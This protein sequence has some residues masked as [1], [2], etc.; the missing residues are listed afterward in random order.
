VE[1]LATLGG[2]A[3]HELRQLRATLLHREAIVAQMTDRPRAAE[4]LCDKLLR[5]HGDVPSYL[6]GR[7]FTQLINARR[8]QFKL[9]EIDRLDALARQHNIDAKS[10]LVTVVHDCVIGVA[11]QMAGRT[12]AAVSSLR[13]ALRAAAQVDGRGGAYGAIAALPLAEIHF[14]RNEIESARKLV[15]DFLP[16]A[17]DGGLGDQ[18][19]SGWLTRARLA[20]LESGEAPALAVLEEAAIIASQRG[21]RRMRLIVGAE[22]IKLLIRVG[23]TTDA[24]H[25]AHEIQV[26]RDSAR[27]L[28]SRRATLQEEAEALAWVRL[29]QAHNRITEALHVAKQWRSHLATHG[30]RGHL[31]CWEILLVQLFLLQGQECAATRA[32]RSALT[33]AAPGRLIRPF[34]DEGPAVASLIL[35]HAQCQSGSTDAAE[36]FAALIASELQ[37]GVASVAE[38][39]AGIVSAHLAAALSQTEI[40]VLAMAGSGMRNCDVGAR[41]GMTEGSVKWCLQQI[42]DKIGVRKRSQAVDRA[43]RLGLIA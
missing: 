24:E 43:R 20:Q 15:A 13:G 29:A 38:T 17:R 37:S 16:I 23:R 12:D 8:C 2:I 7:L 27:V 19:V 28:P 39:D 11:M 32:L 3:E 5:E 21:F 4:Q 22:R 26:P 14:G 40:R 25:V 36:E 30:A 42:Y 41:L 35:R 18:L 33:S 9:A 10:P 6:K 31:A 1:E 34:L